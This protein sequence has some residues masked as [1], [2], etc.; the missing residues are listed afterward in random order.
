MIRKIN[1]IL[2]ADPTSRVIVFVQWKS[3]RR[4]VAAAFAEF[5]VAFYDL[6]GTVWERGDI[7]QDFQGAP[8][9]DVS[10]PK[11]LLLSLGDSASGT[12]L[13][14]ANHIVLIHPMSAATSELAVSYEMQ[15]IGRCMRF[16]QTRPVHLW[17]FVTLQTIEEDI[18]ASCQVLHESRARQQ[19]DWTAAQH[20]AAQHTAAHQ[21]RHASLSAASSSSSSGCCDEEFF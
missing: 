2:R 4:K 14:R 8:D 12:N 17:R 21:Q 7:L 18:S 20:T 13:T 6:S 15:A 5:G 19:E 9:N 3:L 10:G 1:D 11:V 16:G